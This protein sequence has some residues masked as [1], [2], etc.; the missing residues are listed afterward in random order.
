MN[1]L[2]III[3]RSKTARARPAC[4][5][6]AVCV[7]SFGKIAEVRTV[8]DTTPFDRDDSKNEACSVMLFDNIYIFIKNIYLF[9]VIIIK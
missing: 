5:A 1:L 7:R 3:S 2:D 8:T 9:I 4:R 6:R